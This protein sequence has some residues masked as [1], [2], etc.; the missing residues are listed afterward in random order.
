M[1]A[2]VVTLRPPVLPPLWLAGLLFASF[3]LALQV[4]AVLV[5]VPAARNNA[6]DFEIFTNAGQ[7]IASGRSPYVEPLYRWHPMAAY[8]FA[9]P[10][11]LLGWSLLHFVVLGFLPWRLALIVGTSW[12][13]WFEVD[14]GNAVIFQAVAGYMALRG[15]RAAEVAWLAL[16][17][18]IPR[19]LVLPVTAWLVWQRPHTRPLFALILGAGL[20][21]AVPY[22]EWFARLTTSG[23]DMAN[24]WNLAPSRW[25]GWWWLGMALPLAGW[26]TWKGRLGFASVVVS[27]YILPQ[28]LLMLLLP[29]GTAPRSP[30]AARPVPYVS[31]T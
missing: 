9:L 16:A 4:M 2:P 11:G 21:S 29:G 22:P 8:L 15:Y 28:Y 14:I 3:L 13:F 6:I 19:P 30:D 27:P 5:L 25:I 17:V 12:P 23:G 20:L 1:R 26:L 7:L 18:L 10:I 24:A 31:D